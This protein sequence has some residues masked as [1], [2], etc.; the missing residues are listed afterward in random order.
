MNVANW[1]Q[2]I[3]AAIGIVGGVVISLRWVIKH[4]LAELKPNGGS[5]LSDLLRL[6]ILPLVEDLKSNQT[7]IARKLDKV[8]S[9]VDNLKGRFEQH[10]VEGE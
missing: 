4:Y 10:G 9:K 8:E 7:E 5:S 1:L 6:Q 3:S 2:A